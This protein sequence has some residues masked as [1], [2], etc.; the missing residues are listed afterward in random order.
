M[1]VV[2]HHQNFT[3]I[4]PEKQEMPTSADFP[5]SGKYRQVSKICQLYQSLERG[6]RHA[7]ITNL[8][9][10]PS[11][12]NPRLSGCCQQAMAAA[13]STLHLLHQILESLSWRLLWENVTPSWPTCVR[14][15]S[16]TSRLS[17]GFTRRRNVFGSASWGGWRTCMRADCGLP[18]RRR[19][20]WS[21][22]SWCRRTRYVLVTASWPLTWA[23]MGCRRRN[24]AE[25][26]R[27]RPH[28]LPI[29]ST[30]KCTQ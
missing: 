26:D 17:S 16:T 25:G 3:S 8:G 5:R 30:N 7:E 18:H 11:A 19:W 27:H 22:C 24:R 21:R 4:R 6:F 9:L 23:R 13:R 2:N 14:P 12:P 20:N 15:W 29:T 10:L 1:C 28:E